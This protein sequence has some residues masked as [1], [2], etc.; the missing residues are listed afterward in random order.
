MAT[1]VVTKTAWKLRKYFS[2]FF[3]TPLFCELLAAGFLSPVL[4]TALVL[5]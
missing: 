1:P 5:G 3:I 4:G 2:R